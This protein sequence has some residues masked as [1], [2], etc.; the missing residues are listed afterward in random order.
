MTNKREIPCFIGCEE[1]K[2]FFF[3]CIQ[4]EE[5]GSYKYEG[6]SHGRVARL[7]FY[8]IDSNNMPC[9]L[10]NAVYVELK[11]FDEKNQLIHIEHGKRDYYRKWT[12]NE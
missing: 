12:E 10:E 9:E 2:E 4:T 1:Y 8:F 11:E 7:H 3:K 5:K 6:A